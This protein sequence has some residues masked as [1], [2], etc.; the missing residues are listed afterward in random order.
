MR[1]RPRLVAWVLLFLAI[2]LLAALPAVGGREVEDRE[3]PPLTVVVQ[4]GDS[5]WTI[6]DQHRD[7]AHDV[8][9]VVALIA[10]ANDV[11]PG[12]LRPGMRLTIPVDCQ[13]RDSR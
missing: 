5:L 7:P 9:D 3:R 6:A 1:R 8:R 10:A 12:K 11:N 13:P 2:G 4:Y